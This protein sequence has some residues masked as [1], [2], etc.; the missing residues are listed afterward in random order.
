MPRLH[1]F[2]ATRIAGVAGGGS[3]RPLLVETEAG[4][5][6]VKLVGG[7]DGPRALA[8]EWIGTSLAALAGL[9]TLELAALDLD[10][11]LAAPLVESEL[12]EAV[13]RG[14]G[15]C[16]GL[17]ELSGARQARARELEQADDDFAVRLLWVDLLLQNP[18]RRSENPNVLSRDQA[19]IAID[20]ASALPFHHDWVLSEALPSKDLAPPSTHVFASRAARLPQ[21]HPHLRPLL[22][23]ELL[24]EVCAE[25]PIEWLGQPSF[26][27]PERQRQAYAA[28]LWKRLHA[29]DI[30]LAADGT[31]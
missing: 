23:R 27:S 12:R 7:P 11:E 20:H 25:L 21:W 17:R 24:L 6:V 30:A 5:F 15:L 26:D 2:T 19:L 22:S 9:P 1:R 28:Y 16:L 29:M 10:P 8:A 14:A 31:S 13:Q 4:R 18:D 3:S